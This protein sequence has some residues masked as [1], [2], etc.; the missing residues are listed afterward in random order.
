MACL[1]HIALESEGHCSEDEN[2]ESTEMYGRVQR[3]EITRR[4]RNDAKLLLVFLLI[5]AGCGVPGMV[6]AGQSLRAPSP[7]ATAV[8]LAPARFPQD[9]AP[10]RNLTEW[11]YYTGHLQGADAAGQAHNYGFELTFFQVL[12]GGV[13]P[14]YIGHYAISDI[15]R[16]QFHYDQRLLMEPNAILPNGTT[17]T[18]FDLTIADWTMRGVN[19]LDALAA[20]MTDYAIQL[21]LQGA[22]PPALHGGDGIIQYGVFG[23]SYYYSRTRMAVTGTM[24][25][26]GATFPVTGTAWMD[27]QWG[28]F[29][30]TVGG[31]WDWFSIQL[32]N[33]TEYMIYFLRDG[34]GKII[35]TVATQVNAQGQAMQLPGATIQEQATDHWTSPATHVTYPS[36]WTITLPAGPLMITP[37]L[38]DQELV[39]TQ[40]TSN[41]YWEGACAIAGTL[42]G[43]PV[44]GQ[45]YT[46]LTGYA[47]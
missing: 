25:D 31:G 23:F 13:A 5:L 21:T 30:S 2:T 11:W 41:T 35:Q 29:I 28:D 4:G 6:P 47:P 22:K 12:R 15:T 20:S 40:S 10:H 32:D 43:Q 3:R 16:G 36:G 26:H 46:E 45:G 33:G 24:Q 27:H 14:V 37:L 34:N 19:G 9:E 1:S 8:P 39:T 18:G 38:R 42:A 44:T 7:T 17:T